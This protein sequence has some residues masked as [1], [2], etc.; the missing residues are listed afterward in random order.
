[1]LFLIGFSQMGYHVF[2]VAYQLYIKEEMREAVLHMA[3]RKDLT[4]ISYADHQSEIEWQEEGKEFSFKGEMYDVAFADTV[5]GKILLYC[6]DDTREAALVKHY[7][8]TNKSSSPLSKK[9]ASP[10]F[11]STDLFCISHAPQMQSFPSKASYFIK[12]S[13]MPVPGISRISPP[14][15][16]FLS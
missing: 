2:T 11:S 12:S 1:M 6:A 8:S 4:C 10:S 3:D 9:S 7:N 5:S 14:P 13:S 15:P 16:K